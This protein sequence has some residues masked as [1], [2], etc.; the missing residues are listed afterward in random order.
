MADSKFGRFEKSTVVQHIFENYH[1]IGVNCLTL[2]KTVI[3]KN[4][5]DVMNP[6]RPSTGRLWTY[7]LIFSI[8]NNVLT[9]KKI[10][11]IKLKINVV[12]F[13]NNCKFRDIH[14]RLEIFYRENVGNIKIIPLRH[15]W[16]GTSLS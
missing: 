11:E 4:P 12:K 8:G 1:K 10:V 2:V 7:K 14:E 16:S 3:F 13:V 9:N 5:D 15:W 6:I